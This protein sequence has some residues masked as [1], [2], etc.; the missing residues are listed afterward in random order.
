MQSYLVFVATCFGLVIGSFLNVVIHRVP[1]GESVVH[2]PSRCPGCGAG[3]R[4]FDNVPVFAWLWLR[5]R[6]RDCGEP[7]SMRYPLI[8]ALTG[9][10]F[11][12]IAWQFGVTPLSVLY[13][14]FAAALIC[15]SMIDFDHQIIPDEISIGGLAIALVAVPSATAWMGR[16]SLVDAAVHSGVGALVGGGSLWLVAFVHARLSVAMGREFAHWPGEGE[17]LPRPSEADYWLWFPGLGLG[18]VKLLAMI[19][20]VIGPLGVLDTIVTASAVGLVM[21]VGWAVVKGSWDSPFGFGPAL[22]FGALLA[23]LLPEHLVV[24]LARWQG[25]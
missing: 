24:L 19:G 22:G 23:L 14:L 15:A 2:P 17:A 16:M 13:M 11:G 12:L 20:A 1:L 3:I 25:V 10:M 7:I 8:E 5:G 4:A 21:G 9:A 18:D 6:C